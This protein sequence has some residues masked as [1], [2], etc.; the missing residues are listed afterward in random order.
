MCPAGHD[1]KEPQVTYSHLWL[2]P[3]PR[4]VWCWKHA[5]EGEIKPLDKER[6][7]REVESKVVD[8]VHP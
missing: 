7:S 8:M 2:V 4:E 6:W 1:D 3:E 5:A